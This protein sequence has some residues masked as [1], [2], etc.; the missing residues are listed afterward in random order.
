MRRDGRRIPY[1]PPPVLAL[2]VGARPLAHGRR[3]ALPLFLAAFFAAWSLRATVFFAVDES[4]PSAIGRALYSNAVKL[5]MWVVPAAAFAYWRRREAPARYLGLSV[6]P[7]THTW[8][9]CLT[10]TAAFVLSVA[11][12]DLIVAGK[13]LSTEFVSSAPVVVLDRLG[14]SL[15][16]AGVERRRWRVFATS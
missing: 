13:H 7:S 16:R 9:M 3:A 8:L 10:A 6:A 15:R 12:F 2:P 4:I 5:G 1:A 11:L 14:R